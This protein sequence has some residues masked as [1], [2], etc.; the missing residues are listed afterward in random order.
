MTKLAYRIEKGRL[1]RME[2]QFFDL[3]QPIPRPYSS[4]EPPYV[5]LER[6]TIEGTPQG[7]TLAHRRGAVP[8]PE[9]E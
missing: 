4:E 7:V 3:A 5:L 2:L 6:H 9:K 8:L 1:G